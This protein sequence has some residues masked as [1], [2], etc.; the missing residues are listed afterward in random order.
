MR[1]DLSFE[2]GM[3]KAYVDNETGSGAMPN[4]SIGNLGCTSI[5]KGIDI[6]LYLNNLDAVGVHWFDTPMGAVEHYRIYYTKS[7]Y[8]KI[9]YIDKNRNYKSFKSVSPLL[10]NVNPNTFNNLKMKTCDSGNIEFY[11]NKKLILTVKRD[12][13]KLYVARFFIAYRTENKKVYSKENP[14]IA[15]FKINSEQF[16][17]Y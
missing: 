7:G 3:I 10:S 2:N 4:L 16:F 9:D 5:A 8:F 15:C 13:L 14:G 1:D 17:M 12:E 11:M 6:D